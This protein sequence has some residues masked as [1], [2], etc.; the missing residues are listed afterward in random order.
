MKRD[1]R[2]MAVY[3]IRRANNPDWK[4][5]QARATLGQSSPRSPLPSHHHF[6]L[7]IECLHDLILS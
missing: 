4:V 7:S 2:I 5:T 3:Q 1:S 6:Y